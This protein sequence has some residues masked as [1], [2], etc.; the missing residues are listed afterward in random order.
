MNNKIIEKYIQFAIE[1][2]YN[3]FWKFDISNDNDWLPSDWIWIT[4][5]SLDVDYFGYERIEAEYILEQLI[6]SKDF[7]EAIAKWIKKEVEETHW[8]SLLEWCV[9]MVY[10][11]VRCI[12]WD[13]ALIYD[14]TTQQ[15]IA[16][17]DNKLEEFITNLLDLWNAK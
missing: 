13:D 16:I 3:W 17:R 5:Y 4:F 6:T 11:W 9:S 12:E 14:I 7:I 8:N 15:A 2:W 1:N 10:R